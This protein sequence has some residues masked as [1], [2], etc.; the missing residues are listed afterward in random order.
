MGSEFCPLSLGWIS[1]LQSSHTS[2][3][4][5]T[6]LFLLKQPQPRAVRPKMAIPPEV[7]ARLG[8]AKDLEGLSDADLKAVLK[9]YYDRWVE[10]ESQNM[11]LNATFTSR[12]C[13]FTIWRWRFRHA[14]Q[15]H[16]SQVEEGAQLQ[17]DGRRRINSRLDFVV[18]SK[19]LSNLI[20]STTKTYQPIKTNL[21]KFYSKIKHTTTLPMMNNRIL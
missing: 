15:I 12:T 20:S 14:R 16:P 19:L 2:T 21:K 8:P 7:E 17:A 10:A 6:P 5:T 3:S 9:E 4:S 18:I 11:M 13:K 1:P